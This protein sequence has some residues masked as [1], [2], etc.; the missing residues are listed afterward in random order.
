MKNLVSTLFLLLLLGCSPDKLGGCLKSS[1]DIVQREIAVP[2]FTKI[3]VWDRTKLFIQQGTEQKVVVETGENLIDQIKISVVG[4]K[5][6]IHNNNSCNFTRD[7]GITKI[8]VTSPNITEIRSSTGYLVESIGTLKFQDLTLLSE[9]YKSGG[10]YHTDGDFKLD[11]D[12]ENLNVTANG[13]SKFYLSGKANRANFGLYAGDCRVYS[14]GLI[15]QNLEIYHR[16]SGPMVVNPQQSIKG[17]I[18]SLGN[19]ISKNRP[20]IVEVEELYRGR[21]IFE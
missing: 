9:D 13:L 10:E 20:S 12:V 15:V 16:S 6:E 19:V 4:G 18:V 21:L 8:Y 14:E 5:L 1:G 11:L 3:L 2:S 7:Y 17:K